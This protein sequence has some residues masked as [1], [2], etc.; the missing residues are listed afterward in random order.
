MIVLL[1]RIANQLLTATATY[2]LNAKVLVSLANTMLVH[3]LIHQHTTLSCPTNF[4]VLRQLAALITPPMLMNSTLAKT[5]LTTLSTSLAQ[6][7]ST[8]SSPTVRTTVAKVTRRLTDVPT[9][10][11]ESS[12]QTTSQAPS[13]HHVSAKAIALLNAKFNDNADHY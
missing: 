11:K 9:R 4:I 3:M 1:F 6:S 7:L 13:Q 10:S 2:L 8:R 5:L 12:L